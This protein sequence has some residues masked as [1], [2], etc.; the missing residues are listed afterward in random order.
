MYGQVL[1]RY[2]FIEIQVGE[3]GVHRKEGLVPRDHI[4]EP[5]WYIAED[6]PRFQRGP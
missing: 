1:I 3:G 5:Q 2:K 4:Q 6:L